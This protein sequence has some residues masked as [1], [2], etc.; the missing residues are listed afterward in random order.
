MVAGIYF[1]TTRTRARLA[2]LDRSWLALGWLPSLHALQRFDGAAW[3]PLDVMDRPEAKKHLD[4]PDCA[5]LDQWAGH[6]PHYFRHYWL[7]QFTVAVSIAA[8]L[9]KNRKN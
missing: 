7:K 6:D 1:P 8:H 5:R 2:Y 4:I 9:I 3:C